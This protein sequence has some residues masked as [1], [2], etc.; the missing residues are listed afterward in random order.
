MLQRE[1]ELR[2]SEAVQQRFTAA[3][4]SGTSEWMDV[5]REVQLEVLKE[6]HYEE[7]SL[8]ALHAFRLAAQKYPE[9]SMYIRENRAR[10]GTLVVGDDAPNVQVVAL[11]G[12]TTRLLDYSNGDRPLVV[13]AGSYS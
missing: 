7:D 2:W 9:I 10:A 1:E 11:N 13:V 3:E 6:F 5:A 8:V 12:T 4:A